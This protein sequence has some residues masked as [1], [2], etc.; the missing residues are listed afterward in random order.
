[1]ERRRQSQP[2]NGFDESIEVED[3]AR[4]ILHGRATTGE[5]LALVLSSLP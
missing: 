2:N 1:M 4:D 3:A 5:T